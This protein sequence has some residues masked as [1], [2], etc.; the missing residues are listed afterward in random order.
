MY[1]EKD[2]SSN[3]TKFLRIQASASSKNSF[4]D[5]MEFWPSMVNGVTTYICCCSIKSICMY[6][7]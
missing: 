2:G 3:A 1:D 4:E 5:Q 7:E 6:I